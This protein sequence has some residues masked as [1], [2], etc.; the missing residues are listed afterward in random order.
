MTNY[1]FLTLDLEDWYHLEYFQKYD[2]SKDSIMVNEVFPFFDLL[3]KYNIKITVF[4]LGELIEKHSELIVYISDRGHEI[5]IHGWDHIL[6]H[7][8]TTK[9]FLDEILKNKK[10]LEKLIEK[11]VIGYRAP[12]FSLNNEKLDAIKTI[13]IKYD[14]SYIKFK[15]HPLYGSLSMSNF[16]KIDNLIYE[17]EGFYEFEIPTISIL[18][19]KIPIS[20][21][22][23]FR[24]FSKFIFLKLW[25]KYLKF[26]HNFNMYIHPFE[27]TNRQ[28]N[29]KNIGLI[30]KY[31]FTVGRK[32]NLTKLEWFLKIAK[33][34]DFKFIS[35][36]GWIEEHESF[37]N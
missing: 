16:N 1:F 37:N 12:C 5:G 8:K 34:N 18:N 32:N 2:V 10:D 14:S 19:K 15:E 23:Y 11:P 30:D 13:G 4:V 9:S 26:N 7:K 24:L 6:L 33:S 22:G 31:R 21:G 29:L 28:V 35:I 27:L 25:K 36:Q 17:K 20:G 3:D